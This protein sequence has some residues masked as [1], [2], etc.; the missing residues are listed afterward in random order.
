MD[1]DKVVCSCLNITNGMIKDAVEA[2]ATTLEEVQEKTGAG[3][4]CGVCLDDVQHLVEQFVA[5][6]GK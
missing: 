4:V 3:T 1:F 2:G 5:E 6:C